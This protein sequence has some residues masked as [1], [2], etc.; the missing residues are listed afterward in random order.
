MTTTSNAFTAL[1][2]SDNINNLISYWDKD[3]VCRFANNKFSRWFGRT[4]SELIGIATLKV[5]LG[6]AY[7]LHIPFI[8]K[9]FEGKNQLY[10]YE[11]LFF[12]GDRYRATAN[13]YPDME[14]RELSGFFLH[15]VIRRPNSELLNKNVRNIN[16][17]MQ[18]VAQYLETQLLSGFPSIDY[19]ADLH[20]I[21]VSKLMRD[22]KNT[23]N[24]SPFMY[25]RKLQMEFASQYIQE[26]G[27][28]KKQIA[29]MLGFSNPGNF[30]CCYNRWIKNQPVKKSHN[31]DP[32]SP[33]EH[34]RLFISQLPV[35]VA[36]VDNDMNYLAVSKKWISDFYL[37]GINLVKKNLF[38]FF[39]D[40]NIKWRRIE[41]QC[42]AGETRIIERDYFESVN[43][44]KV[45]L[46]CDIRPWFD[47][48]DK[49]GGLIIYTSKL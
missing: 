47:E 8:E 18:Q 20:F 4:P 10:E 9:V 13:Y 14:N 43:G 1:S 2:S 11:M 26:T 21:S 32:M 6:T 15:I 7:H 28:T 45:W 5:L 44:K 48:K 19:L 35:A 23:F 46:Q 42:L 16:H 27:C 49:I 41:K 25:Y 38:D 3:M 30:T 22:F 29:L 31:N 40:K 17:K 37:S 33:V 36:I 39:P 34:H 12:S 24:I